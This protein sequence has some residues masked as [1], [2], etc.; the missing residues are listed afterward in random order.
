VWERDG[1][2]CDRGAT[3]TAVR[4]APVLAAQHLAAAAPLEDKLFGKDLQINF[5]FSRGWFSYNIMAEFNF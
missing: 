5:L 3:A 2:G 4:H 1:G